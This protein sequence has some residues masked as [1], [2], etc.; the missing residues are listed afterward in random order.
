M[1]KRK[2][3]RAGKRGKICFTQNS[4]EDSYLLSWHHFIGREFL[5]F[6]RIVE[7]SSRSQV[8]GKQRFFLD[9]LTMKMNAL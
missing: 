4:D 8:V 2:Y 5:T 6:Q 3:M 9:H 1:K 7:S